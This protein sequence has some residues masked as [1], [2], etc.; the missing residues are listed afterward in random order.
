[1]RVCYLFV[2]LHYYTIYSAIFNPTPG[3]PY[4]VNNKTYAERGDEWVDSAYP[5][6]NF[7][8]G[9]YQQPL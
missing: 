7:I 9:T 8:Q 6:I 3:N 2:H 5:G 4:G 1:V